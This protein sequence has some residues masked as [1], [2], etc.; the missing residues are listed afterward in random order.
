MK[1]NK[2]QVIIAGAGIAGFS[3]AIQL[4]EKKIPCVVL[5]ARTSFG[6]ATTGVRISAKG[7]RVLECII[8]IILTTYSYHLD[9]LFRRC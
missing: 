6:V 5:E 7:V 4:A 8:P 9:H 1:N 3:L 2:D